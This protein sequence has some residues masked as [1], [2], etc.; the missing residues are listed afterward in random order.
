MMT[1]SSIARLC[2]AAAAI[3]LFGCSSNNDVT[4]TS[5]PAAAF[6]GSWTFGSGSIQ[7]VCSGITITPFDLTGDTMTITRVDDTHVA[8]MLMG[9]G[10]MCDVSFTVSGTTATAVSGQTCAVT[11]NAGTLGNIPVTINIT[12]WTM[13]VSGNSLTIAMNGTA[14]AAGVL[15][16]APTADGMATRANGG[17]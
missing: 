7:P 10:V 12:S 17:G 6:A 9:N 2:G 5:N 15:T 11:V 3:F 14:T 1:T 16:C 4:G 8:T 13:N